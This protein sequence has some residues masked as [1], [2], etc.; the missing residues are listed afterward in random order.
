MG[1]I[2]FGRVEPSFMI[3]GVQK[4]GTTALHEYLLQ[5]E[6]L[7]APVPK[8]LHFFDTLNKINIKDYRKKFPKKFFTRYLSFES[9]PRY[10]YYPGVIETLKKNY[11]NLKLI[12]VLRDPVKRAFSAW[13]MYMQMKSDEKYL[14]FFKNEQQKDPTNIIYSFMSNSENHIFENWIDNEKKILS[15]E[16]IIEPSIIKRGHYKDQLEKLLKYFPSEQ[17]LVISSLE[18]KLN[19]SE[20]LNKVCNFLNISRMNTSSLDLAPKHQ[21]NYSE[22]L[23]PET[24]NQLIKYY[25]S[26]NKGLDKLVDF[27]I[28]W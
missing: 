20:V 2:N 13:N 15:D 7:I 17:L 6:Q 28:N 25:K 11:P 4:G 9:T 1:K 19:T 12:V 23:N 22:K 14:R 21:R 3:I 24:Y 18:L 27:K 5:H 10:M 16:N 8:E 26:K